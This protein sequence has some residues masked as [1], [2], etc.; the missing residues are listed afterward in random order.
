MENIIFQS[1]PSLDTLKSSI[2][3]IQNNS[4]SIII[5]SCDNN[6]YNT[7][8]FSSILK[9]IK[10]P[11]IGGIFPQIIFENKNY[12]QGDIIISLQDE[13]D[14]TIIKEL[15]QKAEDLEDEIEDRIGDLE[16]ETNSMF[17]FVDGLT[18]NINE[19]ISSLFNNFGLN[20]N[21]IGG[22]AGSLSFEQKP[23]IIS[24]EGLV[25]DCA[26]LAL[27]KNQINLG[28]KH[29][30][31]EISDSIKVTKS[32]SNVVEELNYKPAFE[33]YKEIV[34]KHSGKT[35]T[36]ENFFDIAKGYPLGIN[37]ISGEAVVRDPIIL[38]DNKLICVGDVPVNSY[39]NILG[40]SLD[41]LTT[42]AS[43]ASKESNANNKESFT[44]FIDCISR[45]LFLEEDFT[46][47]LDIVY[48]DNKKLVGAL[49]LGE[50]ANNKKHYLEFY[51]KTSVIGNIIE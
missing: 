9:N 7:E 40:G 19:L 15:S 45:V 46:K 8:E 20:I 42:A 13:L 29:G 21:Y 3:K 31:F 32:D 24:N 1:N 23:V 6:N 14:I 36:D 39:V 30:W 28:V 26:I 38:E 33:V 5:L 10:T 47:E 18:K 34:E 22:G 48:S 49:T 11:I 17:V 50:I 51:N 27:S 25:Q 43:Q 2:E 35:F 44:L 16:D 37:K 4:K 41:S 12:E